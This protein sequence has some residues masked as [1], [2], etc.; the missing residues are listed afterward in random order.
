VAVTHA[1][2]FIAGFTIIFLAF[3]ATATVLGRALRY[4][5][6][7]LERVGGVMIVGFGLYLMGAFQWIVLAQER[8]FH[9]QDKPVGY[10]G[11]ALVGLAFGAAG[12]PASARSSAVSSCMPAPRRA[13]A[14]GSCS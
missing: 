11:S 7:W 1:L 3:G 5:H 9:I 13:W 14:R 12:R 4:Q 6:V 2:A 10:L 8:R